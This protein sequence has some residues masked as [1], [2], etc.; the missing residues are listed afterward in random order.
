M[1]HLLSKEYWVQ[2]THALVF[3]WVVIPGKTKNPVVTIPG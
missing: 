2:G 1:D 3:L